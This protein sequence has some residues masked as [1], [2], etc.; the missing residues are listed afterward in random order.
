MIIEK[1]ID[2]EFCDQIIQEEKT[3]EIRIED[4]CKY[5]KGELVL[6]KEVAPC[7]VAAAGKEIKQETGWWILIEI[8]NI[9]RDLPGLEKEYC[10]F[11]FDIIYIK[12]NQENKEE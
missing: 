7:Y 6:L 9:W 11:T 10:I 12:S 1:K 4:D 8:K 3:F 5:K 2:K